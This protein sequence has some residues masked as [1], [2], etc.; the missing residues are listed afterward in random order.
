[1]GKRIGSE[2][3]KTNENKTALLSAR[4]REN[5]IIF[6]KNIENVEYRQVY[7]AE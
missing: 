7:A 2:K 6:A 3:K 4:R 5:Q 1:M